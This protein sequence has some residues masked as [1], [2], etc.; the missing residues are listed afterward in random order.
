MHSQSGG[1]VMAGAMP[2]EWMPP[3]MLHFLAGDAVRTLTVR[4]P[5]GAGKTT[6]ALEVL[7]QFDGYRSFVSARVPREKVL[8][9]H[10]WLSDAQT[11]A[12]DVDEFLRYRGTDSTPGLRVG[13]LRDALQARATDLVE[14]SSVL[15][16]PKRLEQGLSV[17]GD[18]PKLVVIDSWEAWVE[19]VLGSSPLAIEVPTTRWELERSLLDRFG[20]LGARVIL[21]VEREELSRLD[22]VVDGTLALT[23]S[24][25]DGRVDRWLSFRKLRGVEIRS[26][27]YP[28]TLQDGRFHC[29]RP[30]PFHLALIPP[31]EVPDPE[32]AAPGLW[33]GSPPLATHFGRLPIPGSTLCEVDDE[34]PARLPWRLVLSAVTSALRSGGRVVIRPPSH[35]PAREIW[36]ALALLRG[37]LDLEAALRVFSWEKDGTLP[38][39]S[40]G[41]F[42][43]VSDGGPAEA[44]RA[45][46]RL[47]STGFFVQPVPPEARSLAVVFVE[48]TVETPSNSAGLDPFLALADL[49]RRGGNF[50]TL[51]VARS[52]DPFI[53]PIRARSA[54]HVLLSS[55]RGQFFLTGVRPWTPHF[56][57]TLPPSADTTPSHFDLVPIV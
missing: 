34:T 20:D 13:E 48:S 15:A 9:D 45:V 39:T 29:I 8:H 35:L 14:L 33:P 17:H 6:F 40:E 26:L 12:V 21:V 38:G 50:A 28:F 52:S 22:Y 11:P 5:P 30:A 27:S 36:S 49:A 3:E 4:G 18:Q 37:S 24:E 44:Q 23:F 55:S 47:E 31:P 46:E 10:P 1:S 56:A 41:P 16:L 7:E 2:A 42:L 51:I 53:E 57:L 32:P 54:I 43:L 19:N 25:T